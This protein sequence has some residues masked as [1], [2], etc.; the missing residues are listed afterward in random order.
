MTEFDLFEAIGNIDPDKITEADKVRKAPAI[1]KIAS[2]AA[3][4]AIIVFAAHALVPVSNTVDT[5][6]PQKNT[7][8]QA[9]PE[10]KV[11]C[12][13]GEITDKTRCALDLDRPVADPPAGSDDFSYLIECHDIEGCYSEDIIT[14]YE[15]IS[16]AMANKELPFVLT[17]GIYEDPVRVLVRINTQDTLLIDQIK[18][19]DTTGELLEIEYA[20]LSATPELMVDTAQK[21]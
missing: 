6:P 9:D 13:V 15:N 4:L 18:A 1:L 21:E 10:S 8:R 2:L 16:T 3:C 11:K 19:F 20:P 14:L 17:C 7:A 12:P 5:Q